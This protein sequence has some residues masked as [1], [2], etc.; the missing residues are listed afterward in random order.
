MLPQRI[1]ILALLVLPF[2]FSSSLLAQSDK[3]FQRRRQALET[4]AHALHE[5]GQ[6]DLAAAVEQRLQAFDEQ[7]REAEMHRETEHINAEVL[8]MLKVLREEVAT[9][10]AQVAELREQLD[11]RARTEHREAMR[12][13]NVAGA[14]QMSM[15][16]GWEH[17]VTITREEENLYRVKTKA[18]NLAG[19]Y[20]READ[21]LIVE[22][23]QEK[24]MHGLVWQLLDH[25]TLK[26]IEGPDYV[27]S[28]MHRTP[29]KEFIEE[30]AREIKKSEPTPK[31]RR[32][33]LDEDV[34]PFGE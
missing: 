14:W 20:R 12:H 34:D 31:I 15:P 4:A 11:H 23:P 29:A 30:E 25:H 32:E 26:L 9:L 24:R 5:T 13:V 27:G 28:V 17:D 22:T 33:K 16:A 7:R 8:N 6:H 2:A 1:R 21:L 10:N 3:D 18:A 19:I